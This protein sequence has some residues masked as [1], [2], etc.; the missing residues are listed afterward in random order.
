MSDELNLLKTEKEREKEA[1]INQHEKTAKTLQSQV[2]D[3]VS[4]FLNNQ[5]DLFRFENTF[6]NS[7]Y[8][9]HD[10]HNWS[11]VILHSP[12]SLNKLYK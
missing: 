12:I 4:L 5:Y 1:L 11:L 10:L 8:V 6:L 9:N 7:D 3:L 2:E